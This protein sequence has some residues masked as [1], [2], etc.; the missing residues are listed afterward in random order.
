[1]YDVRTYDKTNHI[2]L[3]MCICACYA[4]THSVLQRFERNR[5]TKSKQQQN[6]N[7]RLVIF[8]SY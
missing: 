2:Q 1:M 8:G 3:I 5:K 6:Q 4:P 7:Q